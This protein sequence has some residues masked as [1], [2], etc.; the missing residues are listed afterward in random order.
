MKNHRESLD[1]L[2]QRIYTVALLLALAGAVFAL[3]IGES[4]GS[5]TPFTRG[6]LASVILFEVLA[7]ILVRHQ[8]FLRLTE[9][10]TY[11]VLS[12]VMGSVFLYSLYLAESPLVLR[13]SLLSYYIWL[14][15]VYVLIFFLYS[16]RGALIRSGGL[17]VLLL[18]VSLPHVLLSANPD[19]LFEEFNSLGHHFVATATIIALL[20]F[21]TRVKDRLT[22]AQAAVSK[23]TRI[24]ETD[25][26]TGLPNR[27]RIYDVL[28]QEMYRARRYGGPLSLVLFDI[29]DFKKVNDSLGHDAGD[30][31][32]TEFAGLLGSARRSS[33]QLGRWGG[34]EFILVAPGAGR[35]EAT[36]LAERLRTV[37]EDHHFAAGKLTASFG[38]A[39]FDEDD[40]LASLIKKADVN[41]YEAK[42]GGK[43]RVEV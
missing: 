6:V 37:V 41:L 4:T 25:P 27:R 18:L 21:F 3:A 19:E 24:S 12:A 1:K 33:D 16:G 8:R 30:A 13:T 26:L 2:K 42:T 5:G 28:E 32:L 20:Y 43:N 39:M 15:A 38:V 14:P 17:F 10:L 29:D 36:A 40:D 7:V 31:V 35:E 23:I 34:E 11:I 9:E 22:E